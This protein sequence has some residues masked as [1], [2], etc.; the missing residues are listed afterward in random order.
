MYNTIY[1]RLRYS[2]AVSK[3]K[4]SRMDL[5]QLCDNF[6][7]DALLQCYSDVPGEVQINQIDYYHT[8]SIQ[9]ASR[10]AVGNPLKIITLLFDSGRL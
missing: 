6:S 4:Q 5:I 10:S 9:K 2:F 7:K 3:D 8:R 1:R